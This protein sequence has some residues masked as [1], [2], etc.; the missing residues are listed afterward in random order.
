MAGSAPTTPSAGKPAS[1]HSALMDAVY[2]RQRHI[3]DAS[4]K[5]FLFGRDRLTGELQPGRG[6]HVLEIGC[7]TGRNLILAA[8]RYPDARFFGIDISAAMLETARTSI[9]RARLTH[10]ITLAQGDAA[11]FSPDET[12]HIAGFERVFVSYALS[13][14][15]DWRGALENAYAATLPGGRLHVV[16]FG[17]QERLP[18]PFRALLRAWLKRFH[19]TPRADLPAAFAALDEGSAA[20]V[21]FAAPHGGY[22]WLLTSHRS[23]EGPAASNG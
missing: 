3:Y 5:Y 17:Q 9:E 19:V 10:R 1:G 22:A 23:P 7:G 15:P 12:F 16:D 2:R 4:R 14:I 20:R 11:A 8:R 21:D 13:M 6:D 18:G